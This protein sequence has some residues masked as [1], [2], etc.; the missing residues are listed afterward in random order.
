M[1]DLVD[2]V[3]STGLLAAGTLLLALGLHQVRAPRWWRGSR[4]HVPMRGSGDVVLGTAISAG[5][6]YHLSQI[7]A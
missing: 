5:A 4:W 1:S 7:I 3:S 2:L 6:V